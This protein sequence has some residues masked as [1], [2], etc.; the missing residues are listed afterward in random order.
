MS[1]FEDLGAAIYNNIGCECTVTATLA[2]EKSDDTLSIVDSLTS[3]GLTIEIYTA[4]ARRRFYFS[5]SGSV[6]NSKLVV[7]EHNFF[8]PE[9]I[10]QNPKDYTVTRVTQLMLEYIRSNPDD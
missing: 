6:L 2:T 7:E 10:I 4:E 1:D 5:V 3:T 8:H 9:K